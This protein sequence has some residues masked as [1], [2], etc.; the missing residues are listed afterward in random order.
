MNEYRISKVGLNL[1]VIAQ[2]GQ[3][4]R[5]NEYIRDNGSRYFDICARDKFIRAEEHEEVYT[6]KCDED[7]LPFWIN[8][9]DLNID[10]SLFNNQVECSEDTFLISAFEYGRGMRILRQDYWEALISFIISQNNNISKIKKCVEAICHRFGHVFLYSGEIYYSFPTQEEMKDVTLDDLQGLGL[11]YR[12]KYIWNVCHCSS[13]EIVPDR[14]TLLKLN[15]IGPK[16]ASCVL[17]YGCHKMDE[18]PIDTWMKKIIDDVYG[19]HFD[20]EP[21]YD[22]RGY[23]QQLMFYYYRNLKSRKGS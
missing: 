2:S 23:V 18:F 3:C 22:F 9:F 14:D 20:S 10:Y 13:D 4:F 7:D 11:G 15:G 5:M 19:G 1:H 16:V 21:Y 12:D 8:Y 17:L 6:F